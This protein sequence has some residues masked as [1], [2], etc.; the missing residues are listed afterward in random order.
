MYLCNIFSIKKR[1]PNELNG[2]L[3]DCWL[4]DVN[5]TFRARHVTHTRYTGPLALFRDGVVGT[6]TAGPPSCLSH[7]EAQH[8]DMRT[9]AG[10]HMVHVCRRSA[11]G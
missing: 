3:S 8:V 5:V 6:I 4:P 9:G 2:G 1:Q 10:G 7:R 11:R